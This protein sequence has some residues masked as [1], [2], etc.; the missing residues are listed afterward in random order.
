MTTGQKQRRVGRNVL[1]LIVLIVLAA[2]VAIVPGYGEDQATA[3]S[4]Q[5]PLRVYR[6][7]PRYFADGRGRPVYLT[8]SHV[9]W[10]LVGDKTWE[11]DCRYGSAYPFTFK[12]Y[13]DRLTEHG[14][15]FVRLWTLETATWLECGQWIR[16]TPQPWVRSGP[17]TAADGLPKFDLRR[18]NDA[19]FRRLRNRVAAAS[20][21]NVY[22]SVMLFDG[23]GP[24]WLEHAWRGHPFNGANN[25]NGL[26]ADLN[27][28]GRGVETHTLAS[29]A[30]TALQ[31]RYV[32]KVIDTIGGFDNVLYEIANEPGARSVPWQYHMIRFVKGYEARKGKRH[33][34]GMT[35][36]APDGWNEQLF[37]SPADWISPGG[38]RYVSDPPAA[39]RGKVSIVDTDH[40]CQICGGFDIV[41]RNFTRG[42]NFI[43]M[44][45]GDSDP[46]RVTARWAMGHARG[47]ARRMN[48]A[49]AKPRP[50]LASSGFCLADPK[51]EFLVYQ[52]YRGGI[53]VDLRAVSGGLGGEWLNPVT[54]RTT[55]TKTPGGSRVTL[56]PPFS[57]PA[58]LYLRRR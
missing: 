17:G 23:F 57:G 19:Y 47:Y 26:N 53:T 16:V 10:N 2:A 27:H 4:K 7:N 55:P 6:A 37:D 3:R 54:G 5:G 8:G 11:A 35:L 51:R 43:F 48:L 50:D 58:I 44:D 29:R 38:R 42:H 14:H 13:L 12:A 33:P 45:P 20:R 31:E 41:W 46:Q 40:V 56:T 1:V 21:R 49:R 28:D 15:N 18:F 9:W 39:P 25:V 34:V 22:V 32:R 36:A 24:A 52:P 30:V